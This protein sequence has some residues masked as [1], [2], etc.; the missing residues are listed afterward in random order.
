MSATHHQ[1]LIT[2]Q[3]RLQVSELYLQGWSQSAIATHLGVAQSTVSADL[4]V[5]QQQWR[6]SSLRNF[7]LTREVELRKLD[8]LEREAWAAWERSQ[9]PD[10]SAVVTGDGSGRQTRQSLKHQVGDPRFLDQINKC[11]SQRR[12]ILGLDA[13]FQV[14]DVTPLLAEAPEQRQVR[15]QQ[16]YQTLVVPVPP[17][18]LP[19]DETEE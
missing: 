15:L 5:I 13:P 3:R 10:Q 4:R 12:T 18:G 6:A 9:K 17:P 19:A 8:R 7:D 2:T 14:A 1:R 11:I 16:I